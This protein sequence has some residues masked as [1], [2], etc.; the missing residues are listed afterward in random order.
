M[1]HPT[2]TT[3]MQTK[4]VL[5]LKYTH[6]SK[7]ESNSHSCI[8]Q[9][10][11]RATLSSSIESNLKVGSNLLPAN[12]TLSWSEIHALL[13]KK[14]NRIKTR[15]CVVTSVKIF[16]SG[17]WH[18][19]EHSS[20]SRLVHAHLAVRRE[21]RDDGWIGFIRFRLRR[22]TGRFSFLR[23]IFFLA[24]HDDIAK[25]TFVHSPESTYANF[26]RAIERKKR[27]FLS[28]LDDWSGSFSSFFLPNASP[29][30]WKGQN[31]VWFFCGRG[32]ESLVRRETA[33]GK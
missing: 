6:N 22:T 5:T 16:F 18:A 31:G 9:R 17:Y 1:W 4:A 27:R 7:K 10:K 33:S 14:R 13:K 12:V 20:S 29:A 28:I 24:F 32:V 19:I 3:S 26:R 15:S 30:E 23:T 21:K 25:P 11:G 2:L 8:A